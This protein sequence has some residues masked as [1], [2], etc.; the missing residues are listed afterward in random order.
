MFSDGYGGCLVYKRTSREKKQILRQKHDKW[1]IMD[2][3][4]PPYLPQ[5]KNIQEK[6]F[7][8]IPKSKTQI[9]HILITI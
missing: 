7:Q 2:M 8:N 3:T 5:I 6:M 4:S 1:G 9:C